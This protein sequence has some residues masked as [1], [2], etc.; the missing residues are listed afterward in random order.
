MRR[1]VRSA[2]PSPGA[3]ARRLDLDDLDAEVGE[4]LGAERP[5]DERA[6]F[7]H[8]DAGE[9]TAHGKVLRTKYGI[10]CV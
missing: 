3:L 10:I 4:R 8:H 7:H 9:R 1:H 5:R 2:S 6:Q